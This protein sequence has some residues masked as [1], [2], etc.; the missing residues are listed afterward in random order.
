MTQSTLV[1]GLFGRSTTVDTTVVVVAASA[2]RPIVKRDALVFAEL[3][4]DV[5]HQHLV[6]QR[7][8]SASAARARRCARTGRGRSVAT[9]STST[10]P[11]MTWVSVCA[12]LRCG[13]PGP[14]TTATSLSPVALTKALA[15]SAADCA[16]AADCGQRAASSS[17]GGQDQECAAIRHGVSRPRSMVRR[18]GRR[19]AGSGAAIAGTR[20]ERWPDCRSACPRSATAGAGGTGCGTSHRGRARSS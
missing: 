15:R 1:G 6:E 3:G 7:R 9:P 10:A 12:L 18:T 4:G 5:G 2:L 13:V 19:I 8:C 11:S 20:P 17:G 14:L 16:R